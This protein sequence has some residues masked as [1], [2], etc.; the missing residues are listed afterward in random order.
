MD[1]NSPRKDPYSD[2]AL[3]ERQLEKQ[4]YKNTLTV[5][6]EN[7]AETQEGQ[8]FKPADLVLHRIFRAQNREV[9]LGDDKKNPR[10]KAIFALQ[11]PNNFRGLIKEMMDSE[12]SKIVEG[13]LQQVDRHDDLQENYTA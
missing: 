1:L 13:F 6:D 11:G 12:E 3:A 10:P 4:G 5:V 8:R 2:F 9:F 7:A